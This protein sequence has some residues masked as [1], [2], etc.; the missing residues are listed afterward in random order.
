MTFY[1][2]ITYCMLEKSQKKCNVRCDVYKDSNWARMTGL[3]FGVLIMWKITNWASF[4]HQLL[5][6]SIVLCQLSP[7]PLNKRRSS[8]ILDLLF[9]H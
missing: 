4:Q 9:F 5:G 6:S 2:L 1:T 3:I 7:S 8:S